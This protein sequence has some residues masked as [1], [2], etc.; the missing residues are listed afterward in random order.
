M[1][2]QIQRVKDRSALP[3]RREPYWTTVREG[4]YLGFRKVSAASSG[5]WLARYRDPRTGEQSRKPLGKFDDLPDADRYDAA[6]QAAEDWF[7]HLGAGGAPRAITVRKACEQYVAKLRLERGDVIADDADKRFARLVY[8]EPIAT[9]ELDQLSKRDVVA[10]RE[11]LERRPARVSRSPLKDD[12]RPRSKSTANR[13]MVP[14][15]AALNLARER[16]YATAAVWEIA[17]RPHKK[18]GARRNLYLD[19]AQ[20]AALVGHADAEI[21]PFLEGL[22]RLPLRPGALAALCVEHFDARRGALAIGRDKGGAVRHIKLP[23][24]TVAFFTTQGAD[25]LPLAPLVGRADGRPWTK[26][27]WGGPI[28]SAAAAAGLPQATS[29]YTLRHSTITDLVA[30]GLDLLTV[31][32]ISG[33]SVAM[34]E[35]HYGHLRQDLATEALARLSV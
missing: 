27:S 13:D 16:G 11:V 24:A 30:G 32:Q 22:A 35:T 19:A 1:A 20:R 29:A 8:G 31:A 12:T 10:W 34:I 9:I 3:A 5:T 6:R 17:L 2:N 15:R 25:K 26:D 21:R 18:V 7:D 23:P 14:M 4:R 33:T 28:K